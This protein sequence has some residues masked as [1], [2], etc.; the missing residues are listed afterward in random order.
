MEPQPDRTESRRLWH[1]LA[2]AW[3]VITLLIIIAVPIIT[4]WMARGKSRAEATVRELMRRSGAG[5]YGAAVEEGLV[6]ENA[7]HWLN[8]RDAQWG[9]CSPSL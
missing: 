6:S 4:N 9:R 2:T 3:T 5:D 7:L 8:E 1:N